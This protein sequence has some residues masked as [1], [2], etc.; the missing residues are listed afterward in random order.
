MSNDRLQPYYTPA[1][2]ALASFLGTPLAAAW[3]VG[4][5]LVSADER[6]KAWIA[7][8]I[9]AML[10]FASLLHSFAPSEHFP[11]SGLSLVV[12]VGIYYGSKIWLSSAILKRIACGA[13]QGSW[14]VALGVGL[15]FLG[16]LVGT[17]LIYEEIEAA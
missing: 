12:T 16:A 1:Q 5:L 2:I 8:I 9:A 6:R 3:L 13:K 7:Y 15:A 17:L 4:R 11:R 10:T 14:W